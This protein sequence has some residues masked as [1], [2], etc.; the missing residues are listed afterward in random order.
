MKSALSRGSS[1]L[2]MGGSLLFLGIT[3]SNAISFLITYLIARLYGEQVLGEYN[4]LYSFYMIVVVF[5]VFG[6]DKY[7]V[8][9][10]SSNKN[11][12]EALKYI[13]GNILIFCTFS[14]IIFITFFYL[15]LDFFGLSILGNKN[16]VDKVRYALFFAPLQAISLILYAVVQGMR[17]IFAQTISR[18]LIEPVAKISILFIFYILNLGREYIYS[19][20]AIC[21][22]P[23]VLYLF[24][25]LRNV[26]SGCLTRHIFFSC[27]EFIK[28][29][30]FVFLSNIIS[31]GILRLDIFVLNKYAGVAQVAFYNVPF[32]LCNLLI[33]IPTVFNILLSPIYSEI[34]SEKDFLKLKKMLSQNIRS[35]LY[36]IAPTCCVLISE[37]NFILSL[38]GSEFADYS[39]LVFFFVI[40]QI[41]AAISSLCN[42][43]FLM[44][45]NSQ[46]VFANTIFF[47]V[48]Q[49]IMSFLL[50]PHFGLYGA[51]L[52][53]LIPNILLFFMRFF[54]LYRRYGLFVFDKY[55]VKIGGCS[56]FVYFLTDLINHFFGNALFSFLISFFFSYLFFLSLCW[57]YV[58]NADDKNI[59]LSN[60]HKIF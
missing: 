38:F 46:V 30:S 33:I 54:C 13:V 14:S 60:V 5:C 29:S 8:K 45:G 59:I 49:A 9:F 22:I 24:C 6:A 40:A 56:V 17:N 52:S 48:T 11:S 21:P 37:R 28:F 50:I 23:V 15:F 44:S 36:I 10:V 35:V 18:N 7:V 19:I 43:A 27:A 34:F 51:A 32:Q 3:F 41:L 4:V 57:M 39:Y 26:F 55:H 25:I 12:F 53:V 42:S 31:F 58:D 47:M 2:L 16:L 1:S 20:F